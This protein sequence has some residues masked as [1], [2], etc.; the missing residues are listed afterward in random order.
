[1]QITKYSKRWDEVGAGCPVVSRIRCFGLPSDF[2][3]RYSKFQSTSA[4]IRAVRQDHPSLIFI[5]KSRGGIN[6]EIRIF[7]SSKEYRIFKSPNIR[8]AGMGQ[9][10]W[11]SSRFETS[12]IR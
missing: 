8:N 12:R 3:I 1:F 11:M 5:W 9:G 6:F 10:R 2:D 7:E 4:L